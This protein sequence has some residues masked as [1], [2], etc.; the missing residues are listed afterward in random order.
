MPEQV[1]LI[2]L[3]VEMNSTAALLPWPSRPAA[4]IM[5][6]PV[7]GSFRRATIAKSFDILSAIASPSGGP[8]SSDRGFWTSSF[9]DT[10]PGGTEAPQQIPHCQRCVPLDIDP[11]SMDERE[12]DSLIRSDEFPVSFGPKCRYVDETDAWCD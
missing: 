7:T 10:G 4:I 1:S 5:G 9:P 8:D 3:D 11:E 6:L 2:R 12:T